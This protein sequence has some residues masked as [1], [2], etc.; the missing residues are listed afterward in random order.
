MHNEIENEFK[1]YYTWLYSQPAAADHETIKNFLDPLDLP[2]IGDNQNKLLISQ[3]TDKELDADI[4]KLK[5]NKASG[6]DGFQS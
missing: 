6:S 4:G 2:S 5:T 1:K 3:I